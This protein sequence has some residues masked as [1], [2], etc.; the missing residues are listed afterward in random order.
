MS[1]QQISNN[2]A[3]QRHYELCRDAGT[4][5]GLA[6]M[7]AFRRPPQENTDRGFLEGTANGS[8]FQDTPRAGDFYKARAESAGVSTTGKVYLKQ[9]ADYPGDPRAWVSSRGDVQ[10]VLNERGWGCDGLVRAPMVEKDHGPPVGVD[11]QLLEDCAIEACIND[12]A[13]DERRMKGQ[14]EEIKAETFEKVAPD[15]AK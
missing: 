2:P 14:W 1:Y 13:L 9:L 5:H 12:P 8:Q 7:F 4:P 10:K 15:W 6:E 3:V 11:P